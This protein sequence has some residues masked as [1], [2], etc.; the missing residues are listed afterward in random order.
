MVGEKT[1]LQLRNLGVSKIHTLQQL[2]L[3]TMQRVLGQNGVIIWRKANGLDDTPVVPFREQKSMSKEHTYEQ[4]TIDMAVLKKTIVQ[5]IDQL[6][7]DLRAEGRLTACLT[8]K[9]RYSNFETFT[10]QVK[11]PLTSSDKLLGQKALELFEKLYARRMLI[12]LIGIKLS[13]LVSGSYQTDLFNDAITDLNLMTAMDTI[14]NRFGNLAIM[15]AAS[16]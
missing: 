10:K 15:R 7:Y 14:K 11:L 9:I 4:D 8:L 1:Y 16:L 6:A 2:E 3:K 12:R 5:M 13:D